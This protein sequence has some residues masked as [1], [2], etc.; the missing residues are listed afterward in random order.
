MDAETEATC[1][2]LSLREQ[3]FRIQMA[4]T[5]EIASRLAWNST[6]TVDRCLI[7]IGASEDSRS[8]G[9]ISVNG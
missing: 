8:G 9:A 3:M 1:L 5:A 7:L 6:K 4:A 2:L